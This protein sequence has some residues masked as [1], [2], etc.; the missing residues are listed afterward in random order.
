MISKT[1]KKI[2]ITGAEGFIAHYLIKKLLS[3]NFQVYGSYYKKDVNSQLRL[4]I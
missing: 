3:K 2:L 4:T 1:K